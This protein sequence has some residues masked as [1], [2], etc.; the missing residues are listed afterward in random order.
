[1]L[2]AGLTIGLTWLFIGGMLTVV[3]HLLAYANR[4]IHSK[5]LLVA[6]SVVLL[7]LSAYCTNAI[8]IHPIFG[9]F[10]M[11]LILPRKVLFIELVRAFDQVNAALFLPLYFVYSGLR[12][13][14][15]LLSTPWMWLICLLVLVI[16]CAGKIFGG[17]GAVR[18]MGES[19][20]DALNLGILMNTR[21]LV[22]LVVLNIGLDLGVLSPVMFTM[23]VMMALL[24]TGMASP[25]LSLLGH[26]QKISQETDDELPGSH[27][28]Q[29]LVMRRVT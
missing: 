13:Q 18:M 21:G 15:G 2:S 25:L 1:M 4:H 29:T 5:Q 16:A 11:G 19:W 14:I 17:T 23:L 26:K 9:A 22:E 28:D 8:G 7:L 24:T 10:L 6:L 27:S 3:R 12:T 20:R